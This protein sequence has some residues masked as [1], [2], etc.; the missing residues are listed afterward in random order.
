MAHIS[1]FFAM[2]KNTTA[3]IEA[4]GE[5]NRIHLSQ[6]AADQLIAGNKSH[7]I[8]ARE[9]K[10]SAKGKGLMNTYWLNTK[11]KA[12]AGSSSG[13]ASSERHTIDFGSASAA[14][15][16]FAD[17]TKIN[18]NAQEAKVSA[19]NSKI[20]RLVNWNVD[21]MLRTLKLIVARRVS[22]PSDDDVGK[23]VDRH[24]FMISPAKYGKTVIDEV[25]EIIHLPEFDPSAA[26]NQ[27]DPDTIKLDG[28]VMSQLRQY[29]Q[30]IAAMY[31]NNPF[32]NF[33]H[34][35]H[36]TMS[37]SKLLNRIVAPSSLDEKTLKDEDNVHNTLHDHT[38][39]IT[40]DP[41]TQFACLFSALI[42]DV[43]HCGVPNTQL[44]KEN[45]YLASVYKNQS[46]LEQN[47]VDVAWNL[48]MTDS[49]LELRK[50]LCPTEKDMNHFRS[51]V[52]NSVMATDIVDKELK[53]LRNARWEKAFS[54][55]EDGSKAPENSKDAIDR[56][57]TIVIEHLIQASDVSH[58]MQHWHVYRKWNERL[59]EEMYRAYK[60][61]RADKDPAEFWYRK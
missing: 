58:T 61:G 52:V 4:T 29:V 21:V 51:L 5:G 1:S 27:P 57:A 24:S 50:A 28:E 12:G 9:D 10:V 55:S 43:D 60:L 38:Y 18:P 39:G 44:V 3:R 11:F 25:K 22:R 32:H 46:I 34:A 30:I 15:G 2:T 26:Q 49:F 40:S 53:N 35:S 36:V 13:G 54:T 47:S 23:Q 7:W 8:Q 42:H 48:L 31:Q 59:F 37:V 16:D 17:I 56:K 14:D 33:E 20:E 45:S 41:L 6:D 19:F